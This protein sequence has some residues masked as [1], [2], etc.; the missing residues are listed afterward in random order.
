MTKEE[1]EKLVSLRTKLIESYGK[2]THY[3]Q[4]KN[5]IMREHD[6]AALLHETIVHLDSVLGAHVKFD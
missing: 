6:H 5:A 2:L 4:N 3:R 1:I